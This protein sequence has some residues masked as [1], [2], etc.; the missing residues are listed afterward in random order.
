MQRPPPPP[1]HLESAARV[2]PSDL[3][4]ETVSRARSIWGWHGAAAGP[5]ASRS[6]PGV[7]RSTP[8][9][10]GRH[11]A[12]SVPVVPA[13]SPPVPKVSRSSLWPC[14][15]RGVISP[16]S[17]SPF[18]LGATPISHWG[19][20]HF[21]WGPPHSPRGT[22]PFSPGPPF[23]HWGHPIP[24]WGHPLPTTTTHSPPHINPI[25][26]LCPPQARWRCPP[27][28][29]GATRKASAESSSAVTWR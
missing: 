29:C 1:R 7:S 22:P 21:P 9:C 18:P 15:L 5:G 25:P 4:K 20:P 6:V 19:H 24:Q 16:P 12:A 17:Q 3:R 8:R 10:P 11:G 26:I 27:D 28:P 23:S 14:R 13:V 2:P